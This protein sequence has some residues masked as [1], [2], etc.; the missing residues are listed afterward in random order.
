MQIV[1]LIVF[2]IC[3]AGMVGC[4][5]GL[6]CNKRTHKQRLKIIKERI[7]DIYKV[8]YDEHFWTLMRF[9]DPMK[10]YDRR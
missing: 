8:S 10:L 1:L 5:W 6:I 4:T 7:E 2:C 9:K 3:V